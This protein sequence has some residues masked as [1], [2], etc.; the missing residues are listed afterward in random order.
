MRK[1]DF[2][3]DSTGSLVHDAGKE[4]PI[5]SYI[6]TIAPRDAE[7]AVRD[8]YEHQ[9]Q[10]WGYV[11]NYAKSFSHRP[12]VMARW[13][14]L[15]AEIRRPLDD[16]TFELATFAA[17]VELKNTSCALAHGK[18]L[19]PFFSD[20]QILAIA[21]D[22][23]LEFLG[24]GEREIVCFARKVARDA[25]TI[26][27]ADVERLKGCGIDDAMVFDIAAAAAGRAFFA[28][29]LDAVGSMP[30]CAFK[31]IAA[32]FRVPLT[33]GHPVSSLPDEVMNYISD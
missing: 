17:A 33:V 4:E 28:K 22:R 3:Q 10:H 6:K 5:M 26:T 11:P 16:R 1:S 18:A 32:D 12:E 14:R 15:L 29:I 23:D 31:R 21:A 7:G 27:Q 19:K 25:S 24:A 2:G 9:Q 8:M 20:E 13:G 30:D